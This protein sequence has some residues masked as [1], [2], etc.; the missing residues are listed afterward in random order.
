[1]TTTDA[2]TST[3]SSNA[4]TPGPVTGA[5]EFR[6]VPV[7]DLEANPRN[8]RG[9]LALTPEFLAS[10]EANGV[11]QPLHVRHSGESGDS[12][13]GLVVT[14]GHRRLA[15]AIEAG[16]DTVPC[17]IEAA[18]DR[19]AGADYLDM[20][21]ENH[22]RH[23]LTRQ[24]EADALFGAH[25]EGATKKALG[26]AT[27]LKRDAV[28]QALTAGQL[29]TTTR[30]I[31]GTYSDAGYA[32]TLDQLAALA[33]FEDDPDDV[34]RLAYA[35][36]SGRWDYT[37]ERIRAD[38]VER[39]E[40]Q[41]L[42]AELEAAGY[43]VTEHP[44]ESVVRLSDLNHDGEPLTADNHAA[45]DGRG[46][47][48]HAYDPTRFIHYCDDPRRYGHT[49]RNRFEHMADGGAGDR[50][51]AAKKPGE[52]DRKIVVEGN[53]AWKAAATARHA[54]LTRLLARKTPPPEVA[55][56]VA[57]S[58][59]TMPT[60][61]GRWLN[62]APRSS[63]LAQLTGRRDPD[64][65]NNPADP[66][67]MAAWRNA[68]T[69]KRL[70]LVM[71]ASIATAY[72]T[73]LTATSDHNHVWRTDRHAACPRTDAATWLRFLAEVGHTL[74]PIEQAVADDIPYTGD[75]APTG[76]PAGK[77]LATD[78][79]SGADSGA[80]SDADT[81]TDGGTGDDAIVD[82]VT[83]GPDSGDAV[84]ASGGATA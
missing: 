52:P 50:G 75:A 68:A 66:A 18:E 20:Y 56:F 43:S 44:P 15:A 82:S 72:E 83:G 84:D 29:T 2:T 28:N 30:E 51:S 71:L 46:V 19:P 78:A 25:A 27:G 5:C 7:A 34:Q 61:L 33:E 24:E 1:M 53:K 54:F 26:K 73:G 45:C 57:E 77:A 38:R 74:T 64:N 40:H 58:I 59:A 36:A 79:D 76:T 81:G 39:A 42:R 10:V 9:D 70:P 47:Y 80:G 55:R 6:Y 3:T 69:A 65:P 8:V 11:R 67:D 35:A 41:R 49:P 37:I 60:P 16:L 48:W 17:L 12:G 62:D 21:T 63:L 22:H 14:A 32:W 4:G 23:D 31:T 13:G